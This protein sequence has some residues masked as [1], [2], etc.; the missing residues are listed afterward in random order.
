MIKRIKNDRGDST[1]ILGLS[2]L[3]LV[4]LLS[5]FIVDYA[6]NI[7]IKNLY[8]S[9]A[10]KA[11]YT[12]VKEQDAIGGLA[13][14]SADKLVSEYMTNRNR[15]HNTSDTAAHRT[16][17]EL[18]GSYPKISISYGKT[19]KVGSESTTYSSINGQVPY[20]PNK[21]NFFMNKYKAI[22]VQITDVTDN[23]FAGIFGRPCS[24]LTITT[25]AI[26]T[27]QHDAEL[28]K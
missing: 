23:Y 22:Q 2:T 9:F 19:R 6:K 4:L 11:A 3:I 16:S 25:S 15:G 26:A 10:Q 14:S 24:E 1:M 20:I 17:C 8:V 13:P 18:S 12:A 28:I 27:S 5:I 7:Y 21:N